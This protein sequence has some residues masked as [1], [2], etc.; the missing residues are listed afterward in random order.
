MTCIVAI[1]A[2]IGGGKSS[3]V[4]GLATALNDAPTLHFDD[5]EL[6]TEKSP[7]ELA[8]WLT[9]GADFNSLRAP[10]FAEALRTLRRGGVVINPVS[11]ESVRPCE[12]I[13][14]EMPLGR[15]YAETADLIDFLIWVDTPF[16]MAL[17]RNLRGL[18]A[19]TL[20]DQS[21]PREFLHWLDAYLG[22]YNDQV[23]GIL[24]LQKTRVAAAAN[25]LLDGSLPQERLVAD[26]VRAVTE[27]KA[28]T[29]TRRSR[30][31][32]DQA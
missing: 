24:C 4:R 18:V 5:Y 11:G 29:E 30:A 10:G 32:T 15:T 21:D 28:N 27:F 16:D 20:E 25:L 19:E 23:R 13:V 7:A 26:A 6:A 9:D 31:P 1:A 8:R 3:L 12:Y 17:A 14:L 2:P 22:H